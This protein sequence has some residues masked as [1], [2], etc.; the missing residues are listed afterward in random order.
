VGFFNLFEIFFFIS[1]GC[2]GQLT[3]TTTIP[4]GPLNILQIQWAGKAPRGWQGAHRGSNPGQERNKSHDW[5]QRLNQ[6]TCTTTVWNFDC[7]SD[8]DGFSCW[9]FYEHLIWWRW[10]QW[11]GREWWKLG[12]NKTQVRLYFIYSIS[13]I[14]F[15]SNLGIYR[16]FPN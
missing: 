7:I 11:E 2:P 12:M 6:L 4:H 1:V 13:F 15:V 10:W 9:W 3:R 16:I 5:P 14:L 8:H